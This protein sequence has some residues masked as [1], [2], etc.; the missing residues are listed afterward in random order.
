MTEEMTDESF[1]PQLELVVVAGRKQGARV[2]LQYGCPTT[3]GIGYDCDVVLDLPGTDDALSSVGGDT[4][5]TGATNSPV[6][7]LCHSEDQ[8]SFIV[9]TGSVTVDGQNIEP[10][11]ESNLATGTA[12][13]L[14]DHV[15]EVRSN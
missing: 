7:E 15:F 2:A 9:L 12:V 11:M 10:G 13:R 1:E 3:V 5:R 8:L 6:V 14:Q 4:Q